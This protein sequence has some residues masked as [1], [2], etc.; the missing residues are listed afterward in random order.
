MMKRIFVSLALVVSCA[1]FLAACGGSDTAT[2]NASNTTAANKTATTSSPATTTTSTPTTTTT[3]T[4]ATT[5]TTAADDKIGVPECDDFITKYEA[6]ITGK[7]PEAA[8][9]QF[10]STLKQWRDAWRKAAATPQ[11]KA[12]L[13][14]GCKMSAEQARASMK[15]FGCTF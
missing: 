1:L 4:P 5:T 12:G 15:S 3:A 7:V 9:A 6:C 8:R 10:N 13:A 11:G 14:Q 2:D